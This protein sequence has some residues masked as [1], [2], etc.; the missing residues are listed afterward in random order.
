[1]RKLQLDTVVRRAAIAYNGAK[2]D[3]EIREVS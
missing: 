3:D 2:T 1:M